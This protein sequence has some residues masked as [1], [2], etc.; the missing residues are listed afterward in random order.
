MVSKKI[1]FAA[2]FLSAVMC[3]GTVPVSNNAVY[4]ETSA[5]SSVKESAPSNFSYTAKTTSITLKWSDVKGAD[6]YRVYKYDP[7]LKMYKKYK[8]I[9][10]TSCKVTGL[11]KDTKYYF[12]VAVLKKTDNGYTEGAVSGKV[13]AKTKL[14]DLPASPSADF[15]G[16]VKS[17]GKTYHFRDGKLAAGWAVVGENAYYFNKSS[18]EAQTGWMKYGSQTYYFFS[19][20]KMARNATITVDGNRCT[21]DENGILQGELPA[22]YQ[23]SDRGQKIASEMFKYIEQFNSPTSVKI[24]GAYD[25]EPTSDRDTERGYWLKISAENKMGGTTHEWYHIVTSHSG[26]K[27]DDHHSVGFHQ[28]EPIGIYGQ[29]VQIDLDSAM[30]KDELKLLNQAIKD[31]LEE[32]GY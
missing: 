12:K 22:F 23:L 16:L 31:Y 7:K 1:M 6:A 24:T 25:Y 15:T 3:V 30:S 13:S 19:D 8:N 2:A 27:F 4:A 32:L 18:Y 17:E 5:V 14:Y 29:Y 21:F 28:T 9:K 11:S 26:Y 10:G 20:G